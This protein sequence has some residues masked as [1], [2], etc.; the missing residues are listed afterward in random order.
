[1]T[2]ES[3][4]TGTFS[5]FE[6]IEYT[7]TT[8]ELYRNVRYYRATEALIGQI[9]RFFLAT[10]EGTESGIEITWTYNDQR[11]TN[12]GRQMQ[13]ERAIYWVNARKIVGFQDIELI[14]LST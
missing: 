10:R 3:S 14:D 4:T 5:Y 7:C 12:Y 11:A 8:G 6:V 13:T 1:M 2:P 9:A